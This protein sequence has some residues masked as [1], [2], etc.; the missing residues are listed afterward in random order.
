MAMLSGKIKNT[1]C[2][3]H[4]NLPPRR[5]HPCRSVIG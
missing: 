5:F 3:L 4:W 2:S 1:Q